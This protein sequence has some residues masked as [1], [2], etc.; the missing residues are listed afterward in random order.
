MTSRGEYKVVN[1]GPLPEAVAASA[2]IPI[3]FAPVEIPGREEG[4]FADG[5]RLDRV[6][7]GPWRKTKG[8]AGE[9]GEP[10]LAL[11]HLIHRSSP[12]SGKDD[13]MQMGEGN[14]HLVKSPK[15]GKSLLSFGDS[16]SQFRN[17]ACRAAEQL[18]NLKDAKRRKQGSR[19][20]A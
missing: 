12:F 2:A 1:S 14:F 13:V 10:V 6:G 7:L 5:G 17:A 18:A 19:V 4:P 11:V 8:S 20:K 3:L 9:D 15:S 16:Q